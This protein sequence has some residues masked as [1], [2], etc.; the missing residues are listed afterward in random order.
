MP[1]IDPITLVIVHASELVREGFRRVAERGGLV[2]VVLDLA[3]G[4]GLGALWPKDGVQVVVL[5]FDKSVQVVLE[6][7]AWVRH[8]HPGTGVLVLG[9]F[10][11]MLAERFRLANAHALLHPNTP[12]PELL[13]AVDIAS[14]GGV[15]GNSLMLGVL[16]VKKLA[17]RTVLAEQRSHAVLTAREMRVALELCDPSAPTAQQVCVKL[18]IAEG[19]VCSHRANIY[20]KLQVNNQTGLVHLA[21]E[22]GWI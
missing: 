2:Q 5:H 19:T 1:A 8:R 18:G 6:L 13:K 9:E 17:P 4:E 22:L 15:Y 10:T 12:C 7:V 21:R 16:Q 11:P 20:K 3:H 14:R